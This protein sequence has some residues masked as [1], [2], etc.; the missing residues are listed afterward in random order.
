MNLLFAFLAGILTT[1]SPC[2]LPVLP[3]VTAS[4]VSK[5]KFGPIALALG[6]LISFV[7]ASLLIST[8]GLLFGVNP[9]VVRKLA[10][11][12][13]LLSGFFFLSQRLSDWFSAKLSF[14]SNRLGQASSKNHG[15]PLVT[16]FVNGILLGIIWTPCSGPSLGAA[17]GLAAQ[18]GNA[19]RAAMVLLSFGVGAIAP[20]LVFAYGARHFVGNV[21]KH[22]NAIFIV[23]KV[24]GVLIIVFGL[25]IIFGWDRV[26]ESALTNL[27]P[28]FWLNFVTKF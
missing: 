6:L 4:S 12:L 19:Y 18:A 1:L 16:E 23:K 26:F 5:S 14:L 7:S 25:M 17:L 20:L 9:A 21:R 28:E 11:V 10:G 2:V 15:S 22:S 27:L 8:S 13:L 24:F 3:F